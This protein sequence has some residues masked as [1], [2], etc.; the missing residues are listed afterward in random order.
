MK[1]CG[2]CK[3]NKPLTE[4]YKDKNKSDGHATTC[5]TC[6][7]KQK[8]KPE[9]VERRKVQRRKETIR[10]CKHCGNNFKLLPMQGDSSRIICHECDDYFLNKLG[11]K[12]TQ[13]VATNTSHARKRAERDNLPFDIDTDYIYSI[14][15][16]DAICPILKVP[17][18]YN[19][20]YTM[21]IDKI[22]PE[23]GYVKGNVQIIS[24]RANQMKT[25]AT[26]SEL[27]LFAN[28]IQRN[29]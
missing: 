29:F 8:R 25:D 23:L 27:K 19:T 7:Q 5:K 2:L 16:H 10:Q 15:P 20:R 6:R 24:I 22:V 21:S 1:Q 4:F 3:E 18:V 14:I 28:Y 12:L 9:N 13:L 17:M 11:T 26:S